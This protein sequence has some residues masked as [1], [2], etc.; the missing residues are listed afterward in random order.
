MILTCYGGTIDEANVTVADT[1]YAEHVLAAIGPRAHYDSD[2]AV[3][4]LPR[5][6]ADLLKTLPLD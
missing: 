1:C 3:E 5:R 4:G 2:I 6:L